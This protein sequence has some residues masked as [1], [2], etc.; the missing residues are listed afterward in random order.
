MKMPEGAAEEMSKSS[1]FTTVL[2]SAI[3]LFRQV[4]QKTVRMGLLIDLVEANFTESLGDALLRGYNLH[5]S[6]HSIEKDEPSLDGFHS[7][8]EQ[9]VSVAR[10][11]SE[12]HCW[13]SAFVTACTT[14][15]ANANME[16]SSL[17]DL[18]MLLTQTY[19]EIRLLDVEALLQ[20][21]RDVW[22]QCHVLMKS[23]K[24][25]Y[26][27][28]SS[29]ALVNIWVSE[30]TSLVSGETDASSSTMEAGDHAYGDD[31]EEAEGQERSVA[32][33][34]LSNAVNCF[35]LAWRKHRALFQ[36]LF[37]GRLSGVTLGEI[38]NA[39]HNLEENQVE[40]EIQAVQH[41]EELSGKKLDP[42][43][44]RLLE[45][46]AKATEYHTRVS[47]ILEAMVTTGCKKPDALA[48]LCNILAPEQKTERAVTLYSCLSFVDGLKSLLS[49]T[50]DP[51]MSALAREQALEFWEFIRK[52]TQEKF[53]FS[54]LDDTVDEMYGERLLSVDTIRSLADIQWSM[55][56]FLETPPR[57]CNFK[58]FESELS[59]ALSRQDNLDQKILE[60]LE[61]FASVQELMDGLGS[62]TLQASKVVHAALTGGEFAIK[63]A[64]NGVSMLELT[65]AQDGT[66]YSHSKLEDL[67]NIAQLLWS[68]SRE[69]RKPDAAALDEDRVGELK[70]FIDVLAEMFEIC[71]VAY[72]LR[73]SGHVQYQEFEHSFSLSGVDQARIMQ[74]IEEYKL[75]L[76]AKLDIWK[77][78]LQRCRSKYFYLNFFW[79]QQLSMLQRVST[80]K[81]EERAR[82]ELAE[83]SPLH[84]LV[85]DDV[86]CKH[87]I[88]Q[89]ADTN[90]DEVKTGSEPESEHAHR[91]LSA[92]CLEEMEADHDRLLQKIGDHL[93][94]ALGENPWLGSEVRVSHFH[95]QDK[96]TVLPGKLF[97]AVNVVESGSSN[98]LP[99][100]LALYYNTVR[101]LPKPCHILFCHD[102]MT[103]ME[104][105]LFL[106]RCFGSAWRGISN[107]L[108]CLVQPERLTDEVRFSL[109]RRLSMPE[110]PEIPSLL[111]MVS[112]VERGG[113]NYVVEQL[114][115][116]KHMNVPLVQPDSIKHIAE[117]RF[118]SYLVL[119]S[120]VPGLGKTSIAEGAR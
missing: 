32:E 35:E 118:S 97:V 75:Q 51:V 81:L 48:E 79:G 67:R 40:V 109:V 53:N 47:N 82:N 62:R 49:P 41:Y 59:T 42:K 19:T 46:A 18:D 29:W 44:Q 58:E 54:S 50:M 96:A 88:R 64:E 115:D 108:Y 107:A 116:F 73:S 85:G 95:R 61:N 77:T 6:L 11:C 57:Q 43:I 60:G 25:F 37:S 98:L 34:S 45:V 20:N 24:I 89:L 68:R 110:H 9:C 90:L 66:S 112:E 117:S 104:L 21:D 27:L 120:A 84:L 74:Q 52:A 103:E 16:I 69:S 93:E 70:V 36:D 39:F 13:L 10:K 56:V 119:T 7:S 12:E 4:Q 3:E 55:H 14:S 17:A 31:R 22:R 99:T 2:Q 28:Q 65:C 23:A 91:Q 87:V 100:I 106:E 80:E 83:Q 92:K 111:A 1:G 30:M 8:L 86:H 15:A 94:S 33:I 101:S 78:C 63:L 102:K 72:E 114:H 5:C 38:C 105:N 113:I 26:R 71:D 76:T